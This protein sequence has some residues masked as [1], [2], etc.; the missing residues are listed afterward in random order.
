[1]VALNV[2]ARSLEE[3]SEILLAVGVYAMRMFMLWH[4]WHSGMIVVNL[5]YATDDDDEL[6]MVDY[7]LQ[8]T[9]SALSV[10]MARAAATNDDQEFVGF[11]LA[12]RTVQTATMILR[13]G[14]RARPGRMV[15]ERGDRHYVAAMMMPKATSIIF[16]LTEVL[17]LAP[18]IGLGL[19]RTHGEVD[20]SPT[21]GLWCWFVM[22]SLNSAFRL[23][24]GVGSDKHPG[25][26]V[27]GQ[28]GGKYDPVLD[29]E[30]FAERYELIILIFMGELVFAAA[31]P[32]SWT[33]SVATIVTQFAVFIHYFVAMPKHR[34]KPWTICP[35]R[36]FFEAN[37]HYFLFCS[38]GGLGAAYAL[39]I[40]EFV[41][42]H[43]AGGHA[44]ATH[45][46]AEAHHLRFLSHAADPHQ[47]EHAPP[48]GHA[49]ADHEPAGSCALVSTSNVLLSISAGV[50]LLAKALMI[51]NS[52]DP[53]GRHAPKLPNCARFVASLT[54]AVLSIGLWLGQLQC[55]ISALVPWPIPTSY[56]VPT[57]LMA[58]ALVE[59][60]GSQPRE[61]SIL[62]ALW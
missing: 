9:Q 24:A 44:D 51:R 40:H 39:N 59:L 34:S 7:L 52:P 37:L 35:S 47:A 22:V 19:L 11:F 12:A 62:A 38:L 41:H 33:I 32:G 58:T 15:G 8:F 60:W 31:T 46:H 27:N 43:A 14:A 10:F 50:F 61:A 54:A 21:A 4:M 25:A 49:T 5:M 57:I 26:W 36:N 55:A 30:H 48:T 56:A 2:V 6:N 17:P 3:E 29:M 1:V 28:P 42:D 13:V 20:T 16:V 18:A 53:E 45:A 23:L